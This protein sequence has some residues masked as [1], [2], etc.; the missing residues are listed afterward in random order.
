MTAP[1]G[2][3]LIEMMISTSVLAVMAL[4]SFS[5]MRVGSAAYAVT[6]VEGDLQSK[7][8]RAVDQMAT[9]LM[10]SSSTTIWESKSQLAA[11]SR[12]LQFRKNIGYDANK[13]TVIF[14]NFIRLSAELA[15]RKGVAERHVCIRED[16]GLSTQRDLYVVDGVA[17]LLEGETKNGVD[18]N[19]YA[20]LKLADEPGLCFYMDP[21]KPG[22]VMILLTLEEKTPDGVLRQVTAG[23][24]VQLRNP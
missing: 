11:G 18:D 21:Q 17:E 16:A 10:D 23:T 20:G 15:T 5:L 2:L 22:R 6:A 7:A 19:S 1:R 14:G 13:G 9:L 4:A 12:T 8:R 24:V 3:T